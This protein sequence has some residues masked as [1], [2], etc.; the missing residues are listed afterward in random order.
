MSRE[1]FMAAAAASLAAMHPHRL[2]LRGLQDPAEL[3][4]AK[5]AQGVFALVA[6][7]L[8]DWPP[9]TGREGQWGRLDF[10]AVAYLRV[11]DSP[12]DTATLRVEQAEAA[13]E[14]E[15]LAWCQAIKAAPIDAVYPQEATYSRGFEAPQGWVV[16][17]LQGLYV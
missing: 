12:A 14:A 9:V 1:A 15:L 11:P 7:G 3:G 13:M 17:A 10:A 8:R 2:V 4:D 5:L 16:M 6:G